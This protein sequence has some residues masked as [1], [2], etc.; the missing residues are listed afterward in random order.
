[1]QLL[2]IR[3]AVVRI[4]HKDF[5]VFNIGKALKRRLTRIAAG[6]NKDTDLALFTAL[7]ERGCQKMR[8]HLKSHVLKRAGRSVPKLKHSGIIVKKM[9]RSSAFAVKIIAVCTGY[10][11][12]ELSL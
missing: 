12:F 6:G 4:K 10:H 11:R 2:Y 7:F 3:Y 8:K 1:M 9:H 5:C